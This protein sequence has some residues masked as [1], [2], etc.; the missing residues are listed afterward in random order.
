MRFD[1]TKKGFKKWRKVQD[2]K[3]VFNKG[4]LISYNLILSVSKKEIITSQLSTE[5]L[6]GCGFLE[7]LKNLKD[8][9]LTLSKKDSS[10]EAKNI[11]IYLD[12]VSFHRRQFIKKFIVNSGFDLLYGVP[13]TPKYDMVELVFCKLKQVF[14]K[15]LFLGK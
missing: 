8:L 9:L 4:R 13:Y 1:N 10:Y 14:Y 6:N 2:P 5:S 7:Y 12:N 3:E 11:E 15:I